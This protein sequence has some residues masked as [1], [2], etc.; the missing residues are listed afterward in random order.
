MAFYDESDGGLICSN[1][2]R[3]RAGTRTWLDVASRR[4]VG[5]ST[6]RSSGYVAAQGG[7]DLGGCWRRAWLY[8]GTTAYLR[9]VW[10]P[11]KK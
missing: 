3:D 10:H 5:S 7:F 9:S 2:P 1:G 6:L 4:W 8:T 11:H